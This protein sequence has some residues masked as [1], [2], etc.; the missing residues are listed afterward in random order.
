EDEYAA[1]G[2]PFEQRG[3]LL[4]EH[5]AAWEA[6]WSGSPARFHGEHYAFDEVYLEPKAW[7]PEGPRIW[8]GGQTVHARLLRRI[9]RYAHGF[10]PL[11]QPSDDDLERLR[12][13]LAGAGRSLDELE[14]VGGI[15]ARFPDDHRP[16][17]LEPAIAGAAPQVARGFRTLC[18]KPSQFLDER[19]RFGAWCREVVERCAD[20]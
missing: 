2:V 12:A 7:R 6:V 13:G 19:A 17:P 9:V 14:L 15:R 20:L 4:D 18:I 5:L 1:L 3:A 11:G 16:A 10:H 8:L